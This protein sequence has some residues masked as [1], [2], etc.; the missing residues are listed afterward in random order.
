MAVDLI[1]TALHRPT[2]QCLPQVYAEA[3]VGAMK[4]IGTSDELLINWM[5]LAKDRMDEVRKAF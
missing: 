2:C 1:L 3:L 4:G 5:C